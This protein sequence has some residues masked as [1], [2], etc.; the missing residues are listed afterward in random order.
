VLEKAKERAS[1]AVQRAVAKL[2]GR[3][4]A[5]PAA[6]LAIGAGLAWRLAH[7]PPIAS[8]LVGVGCLWRTTPAR[9]G[10]AGCGK[11]ILKGTHEQ[12]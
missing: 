5:N 11:T 2:K 6:A 12:H 1:D 4:A 3:A 8:L 7:R 9:D 10:L